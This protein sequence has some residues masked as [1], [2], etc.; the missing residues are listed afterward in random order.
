MKLDDSIFT[1]T[2]FSPVCSRCRHL[3]P[4][5]LGGQT[6]CLAF[7]RIPDEIWTGKNDHT[8]P[9]PG[10]GGVVFSLAPGIDKKPN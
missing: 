10:D 7:D 4:D 3:Q 2:L 9:F 8:R 6:R 5:F 1:K